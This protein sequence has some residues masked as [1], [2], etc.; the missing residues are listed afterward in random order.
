MRKRL[1]ALR[2][3]SGDYA[4]NEP[5]V[6]TNSCGT[7]TFVL[8]SSKIPVGSLQRDYSL[9]VAVLETPPERKIRVEAKVAGLE[10]AERD[11]NCIYSRL[12]NCKKH[13]QNK[14]R[15]TCEVS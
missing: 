3:N 1:E 15:R 10:E 9:T 12:C 5:Q 8:E 13:Q 7:E 4:G 2:A 6:G 14:E 11:L